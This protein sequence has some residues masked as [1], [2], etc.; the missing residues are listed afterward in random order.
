MWR[1]FFD[2]LFIWKESNEGRRSIYI[3]RMSYLKEKIIS[4]WVHLPI[5]CEFRY[6]TNCFLISNTKNP[7]WVLLS[8]LCIAFKYSKKLPNLQFLCTMLISKVI[9][10]KSYCGLS[11]LVQC[12]TCTFWPFERVLKIESVYLINIFNGHGI[13]NS[14]HHGQTVKILFH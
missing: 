7:F 2:M 3:S 14:L 13:W 8:S 10:Y 11:L 6:S 1:Y 9:V 4:T 12:T 5:R